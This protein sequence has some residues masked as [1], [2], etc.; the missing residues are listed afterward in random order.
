MKKLIIVI[1]IL[2]FLGTARAG[3][4]S[5]SHLPPSRVEFFGQLKSREL[6]IID[7]RNPYF[8]E[9]LGDYPWL[10]RIIQADTF[11][12]DPLGKPRIHSEDCDP[13]LWRQEVLSQKD[14]EIQWTDQVTRYLQS[15]ENQ[16]KTGWNDILSNTLGMMS[17][18]LHP[19]KYPFGRHVLLHLPNQIRIKGL[20]AMKTDGK[21]RPLVILRTGLFSNTQEFYPE[22]FLFFQLF[23][24]SPFHVLVLESS[25]G[26]EFLK[27]NDS[28]SVGGFDE[29]LQ[30]FWIAK[31]LQDR[32][33]PISK[34]IEGVHMSGLSMGGHGVM[35]SALL[36]QLNTAPPAE[37]PIIQ[38]ALALCP[39]LNM[40]ETLDRHM[41]QEISR[42]LMNYWAS[43]RLQVI[44]DKIPG[45]ERHNFI[46]DFLSWIQKSYKGPLISINGKVAGIQLPDA[47]ERIISENQNGSD[48][49]WQLNNYWPWFQ[50]VRT[51]VLILSTRKDPIVSWFL[52]TGRLEEGKLN[53]KDSDVRSFSFSEG[54]HCSLPVAYDWASLATVMQTY[55]L[56]MSPNYQ[57]AKHEIRVPLGENL[58]QRLRQG[59]AP[60]FLDLKF[61]VFL[62]AAEVF[63][64]V[65]F[66]SKATPSF[67]DQVLAPQ[68]TA[69]LPLSE[70]EFPIEKTVLTE[71]ESSLLRRWAY[72]NIRARLDGSEVVFSWEA[73]K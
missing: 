73:T 63:V 4:T 53:L 65:R 61:E 44:K 39:L 35:F 17:F 10:A 46:P 36:N 23:E 7:E 33:Q 9:K 70:M 3:S 71:D 5:S 20:L 1:G 18:K 41:S 32:S 60:P 16:W 24:Q 31:T 28:L 2:H 8:G 47:V 72:Q 56:K 48:L 38:S 42:D 52:N 14:S 54:Y 11:K 67:W 59:K 57:S 13:F 40:Q 62:Q 43:R 69:K 55:F 6:E 26:S 58:E 25:S 27:H 66:V 19:N 45:L 68:M 30:N 22:R 64:T 51:P 50:N 34:Y 29:G 37:K 21:K 15:C 12:W 49:F